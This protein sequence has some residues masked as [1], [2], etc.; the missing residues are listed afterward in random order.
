VARAGYRQG[1]GAL[2]RDVCRNR[3]RG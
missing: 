2:P 1:G 3:C